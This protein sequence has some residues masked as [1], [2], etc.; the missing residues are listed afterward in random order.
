MGKE[1]FIR[2]NHKRPRHVK[3]LMH[4]SQVQQSITTNSPY[5]T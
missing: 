1:D 4:T 3:F 2:K 5:D